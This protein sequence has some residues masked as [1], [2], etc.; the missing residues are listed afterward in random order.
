VANVTADRRR[1]RGL[2]AAGLIDSAGLAFGW[3]VFILAVTARQGLAAAATYQ[4][5]MLVGVA[6]SAP[7]TRWVT[8]R[9]DGRA[10]LR[11]LAVSEGICRAAVL[12]LLLASAPRPVLAAL[13]LVMNVWA[14][15]GYAAMRAEVNA[16]ESGSVS[17]T[18][19][20]LC[21]AGAEALA[22]AAAALLVDPTN[23]AAVFFV[24]PLY[25]VALVPQWWAGGRASV[26]RHPPTGGVESTDS[27]ILARSATLGV[28]ARLLKRLH[29][30]W[31]GAGPWTGGGLVMLAASGPALLASVLAYDRYGRP[32]VAVSAVSL[33]GGALI[34]PHLSARLDRLAT[35][36]ASVVRP[37][38]LW[39]LLGAM[40]VVGWVFAEASIAGLVLAQTMAGMAQ[41]TFEGTMDDHCVRRGSEARITT[42]LS[43]A[44]AS[45]ALGGAA[46]VAVL[47][48][49]LHHTSLSLVAGIAA[50]L[51]LIAAS[52]GMLLLRPPG[53]IRLGARRKLLECWLKGADAVSETQ[54][55][56]K[57]CGDGEARE[58]KAE[59]KQPVLPLRR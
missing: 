27:N 49:I 10:L 53:Q 22:S 36:G 33:T 52:A 51:L 30:P 17:L 42:S 16:M 2:L 55:T 18:R 4:A 41:T 6:L 14:W 19:Y 23:R 9:V 34:G 31:P 24:I 46:A 32:G 20:A 28:G 54:R 37:S 26:V 58:P 47:P 38:V 12:L 43:E 35:S 21:I 7:F 40:M 25:T 45:R 1:L 57:G 5:A 29:L 59:H 13:V 39:P 56:T 11:G 48:A 3:T 50:G 15:T 44:S 8:A